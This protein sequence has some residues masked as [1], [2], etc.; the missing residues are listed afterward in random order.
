MGTASLTEMVQLEDRRASKFTVWARRA[1]RCM[2]RCTGTALGMEG[3]CVGIGV[4]LAEQTISGMGTPAAKATV[5]KRVQDISAAD[6]ATVQKQVQRKSMGIGVSMAERTIRRM[7]TAIGGATVQQQVQGMS[8]GIEVA[9]AELTVRR[10]GTE[11]DRA[12]DQIEVRGI[13]VSIG[14]SD[15]NAWAQRRTRCIAAA[16]G[17][18]T[19][20]GHDFA[21]ATAVH[22]M[23]EH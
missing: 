7:G 1:A 4:S 14:L 9:V 11:A 20:Q 13:S 19:N 22:T 18:A 12:T 16:M 5:Q 2:A 23:Q 3:I 17:I 21:C 15:D 6:R 10:M 8:V